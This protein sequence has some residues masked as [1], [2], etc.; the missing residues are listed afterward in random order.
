MQ[1]CEN[2]T[3]RLLANLY[4]ANEM[5]QPYL[6]SESDKRKLV[7]F[8]LDLSGQLT[9][10][11]SDEK[12][13]DVATD[14]KEKEVSAEND[15]I[16]EQLN[17]VVSKMDL[18]LYALKKG[19]NYC[20]PRKKEFQDLLEK[21]KAL[22]QLGHLND[23]TSQIK[24]SLLKIG[25]S[26]IENL[27][28]FDLRDYDLISELNKKTDF[29]SDKEKQQYIAKIKEMMENHVKTSPADEEGFGRLSDC[30]EHV[31]KL[32]IKPNTIQ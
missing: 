28:N 2:R 15:A 27:Q 19:D 18:T 1:R 8:R 17:T 10:L 29:Q 26:Q 30:H 5:Q 22:Q 14:K 7:L 16:T 12:N 9:K 6:V 25:I 11:K 23:K 20:E 13:K 21:V 32:P 24:V 3:N 4:I 31:K